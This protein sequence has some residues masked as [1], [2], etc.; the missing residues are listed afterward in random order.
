MTRAATRPATTEYAAYYERYVSLVPDG[1]LVAILEQQ[2]ADFEALLASIPESQAD[3]RYAPDKWSVKE[4]VGHVN[5]GERIF[6]YRALRIG[7]GD[8]TPLPGFDQDPYIAAGSFGR[9][10]LADLAEE[11]R[12][13]RR[14]TIALLRGFDEEAWARTGTASDAP[15]S[16]RAVAYIIAGHERH[17]GNILRERYLGR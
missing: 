6:A 2:L 15:V 7:R 5:D 9:R 1:D 16:A 3:Y 4:L 17:H 8:Q 11:F 12:Y 10:T 14:S 13:I